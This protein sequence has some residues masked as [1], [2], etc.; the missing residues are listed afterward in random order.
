MDKKCI[1]RYINERRKEIQINE[2]MVNSKII[3]RK[4]FSM[5]EYIKTECVYIYMD[6]NGEVS[7]KEIIEESLKTGKRVAIPKI[8]NEEMS[9]HYINS[10]EDTQEGYFGVREPIKN[11]LCNEQGII[12]M[13]GVA[14]DKQK[15][16]IGYGKGYYDKYLQN[17]LE[18]YKIA[19][20]F[21][22][23]IFDEIPHEEHDILPNI[24]ITEKQI[25]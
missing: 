25:I 18:L 17:N 9:F 20:A 4:I 13:P 21:E 12:I 6:F 5:E 15:H 10:V 1:R 14:F 24:I 3:S 2:I 19:I 22:F 23:Q 16:R 7:T 11:N 8:E